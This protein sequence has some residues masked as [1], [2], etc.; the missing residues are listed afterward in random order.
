MENYIL[1]NKRHDLRY[2]L[3]CD[4]GNTWLR[5]RLVE[6]KSLRVI[7][8][9]T[10]GPGIEAVNRNW[11]QLPFPKMPRE[12]YYTDVIFRLKHDI[13]MKLKLPLEWTPVVVSGMISSSIGMKELPYKQLPFQL[14]GKNINVHPCQHFYVISGVCSSN[15]VMRGEE[16]KVIGC[17]GFIPESQEDQ[18]LILPGT[19]PKHIVINGSQVVKFQ[20]FMTG[21]LFGLLTNH[22]ILSGSVN[23]EGSLDDPSVQTSFEAGLHA[24]WTGNLLHEMFM[25]RTNILIKNMPLSHNRFY[26]SGLLI[27]S[28]LRSVPGGVPVYLVAGK[29]HAQLYGLA[30]KILGISLAGVIDADEALIR[31]QYA[32]ISDRLSA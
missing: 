23:E 27:G 3:S 12:K 13:A 28:E 30:C 9:D 31:G 29:L 7:A 4:W 16:T 8:E 14:N 26:L 18:W 20:T 21:E 15:D 25:V 22:G 6:T 32:I 17:A 1:F 5:V 2:F 19:H 24:G 11:K 10:S